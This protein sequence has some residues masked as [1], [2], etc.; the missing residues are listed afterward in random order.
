MKRQI[1]VTLSTF[2]IIGLVNLHSTP[3]QT[4]NISK[5]SFPLLEQMITSPSFAIGDS[6]PWVELG[7]KCSSGSDCIGDE[8]G[9]CGGT[10]KQMDCK[11]KQGEHGEMRI[12]VC[13]KS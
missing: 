13:P 10:C 6:E 11:D 7:G 3:E 8:V 2:L 9:C 1:L 4:N 12:C 5:T